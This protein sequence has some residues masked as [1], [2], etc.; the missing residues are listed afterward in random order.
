[1]ENVKWLIYYGLIVTL[2]VLKCRIKH[3]LLM[4]IL[5]LIVTLDVLKSTSILIIGRVGPSLITTLDVS[6][7]Y[8]QSY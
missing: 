1:M 2:D 7:Y 6:K 5:S 8:E 3:L 4:H